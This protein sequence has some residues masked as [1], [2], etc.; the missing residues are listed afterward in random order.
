M[1]IRDSFVD[2]QAE[3]L[4]ALKVQVNEICV[5]H[6]AQDAEAGLK[7]FEE[8]GPFTIVVS[9]QILPGMNG[10]PQSFGTIW[11]F[12]QSKDMPI[13]HRLHRILIIRMPSQEHSCTVGVPV[14]HL[15]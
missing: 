10:F 5:P 14:D 11:F 12:K 2:D 8:E 7:I 1:C 4:D 6:F 13:I 15:G 9:D 3:V